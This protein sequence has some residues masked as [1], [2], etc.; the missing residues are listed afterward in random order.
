MILLY[1]WVS[2][3]QN[4]WR[5]SSVAWWMEKMTVLPFL[6]SLSNKTTN[7]QS[8]ISAFHLH[9][10]RQKQVVRDCAL[11]LKWNVFRLTATVKKK[12]CHEE[13]MSNVVQFSGV[14]NTILTHLWQAVIYHTSLSLKHS[15]TCTVMHS[16]WMMMGRMHWRVFRSRNM[17]F[18]LLKA[19]HSFLKEWTTVQLYTFV[20]R[21]KYSTNGLVSQHI[22]TISLWIQIS[23][24]LISMIKTFYY[25]RFCCQT[26]RFIL[27]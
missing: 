11:Y 20:K 9:K 24:A 4:G 13:N 8:S 23:K 27:L 17:K 6:E 12:T 10:N 21:V 25:V 3:G 15:N 5:W 7:D 14:S 26:D 1:S 18:V 16:Q 22:N 19:P 2:G